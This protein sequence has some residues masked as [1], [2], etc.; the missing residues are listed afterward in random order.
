MA[1]ADVQPAP[2][3][4]SGKFV[5][6]HARVLHPQYFLLRKEGAESTVMPSI[7]WDLE[8]KHRRKGAVWYPSSSR[9]MWKGSMKLSSQQHHP[10]LSQSEQNRQHNPRATEQSSTQVFRR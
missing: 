1:G 7:V 9:C 2:P 10:K 3:A 5:Q 8:T 6:A 4:Q